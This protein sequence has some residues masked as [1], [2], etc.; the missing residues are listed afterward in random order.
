MLDDGAEDA[1]PDPADQ[2]NDLSVKWLTA[3]SY[4]LP[5]VK[6]TVLLLVYLPCKS[7]GLCAS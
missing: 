7:I 5:H 1:R 6:S 3:E 4:R 2:K